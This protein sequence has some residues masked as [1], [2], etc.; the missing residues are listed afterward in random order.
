MRQP[1]LLILAAGIGSRYG[2]FKQIDPVGP[3]GETVLDYAVYD[4]WRAGFGKVVF[5]IRPELESAMRAH[6]DGCLASRLEVA[7]VHQRLA[8]LPAGRTVP[9]T[10]EKPWGTGHAIWSARQ[11]LSDPFAAVNA[12]D[13]YGR[14]SYRILAR[15]FAGETGP[16]H[17]RTYAMVAFRL[18]NTLSRHGTV[19]RGI[20]RVDSDGY[21]QQVVERTRIKPRSGGGA[22][23]QDADGGWKDLS[24]AEPASLNMWGFK[25]SVFEALESE[26]VRF[27]DEKGNDPKAEFFIPTVVDNLIRTGHCRTAVLSTDEHWFGMTYREDR[28]EVRANIRSLIRAGVYPDRLWGES[29]PSPGHADEDGKGAS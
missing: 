24:G 21:L 23:F 4:A 3:S 12:D 6:F 1:S 9:P 26:F 2:G 13:F 5:V 11:A 14:A 27:L 10:R 8:D 22:R 16:E 18:A 7:Y 15:F 29:G 25:P 17:A 19:S 20:C 28:D